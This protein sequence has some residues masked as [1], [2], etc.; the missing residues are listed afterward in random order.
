MIAETAAARGEQ[1]SLLSV[2]RSVSRTFAV[3]VAPALSR[4]GWRISHPAYWFIPA[5]GS[6]ADARMVH[7]FT[8]DDG[9]DAAADRV[10]AVVETRALNADLVDGTDYHLR[11]CVE[12][13]VA[14]FAITDGR[15]WHLYPIVPGVAPGKPSAVCDLFS[16]REE[17]AAAM[18]MLV[19][20]SAP[21]GS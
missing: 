20:R 13:G 18:A 1:F 12:T 17:D 6:D 19:C 16:G 5:S 8:L 15:F 3:L 2:D 9:S 4:L 11:R 14:I 7:A 10:L 21:S